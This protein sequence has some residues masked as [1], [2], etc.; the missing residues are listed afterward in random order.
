MWLKIKFMRISK[1]VLETT[2][3]F[4]CCGLFLVLANKA[5]KKLYYFHVKSFV[6]WSEMPKIDFQSLNIFEFIIL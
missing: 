4:F 5:K 2:S 6:N 1:Q 3:E